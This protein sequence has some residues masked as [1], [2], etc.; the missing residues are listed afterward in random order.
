[1]CDLEISRIGSPY[2]HDISNLKVEANSGKKQ[3]IKFFEITLE[4]REQF[5]DTVRGKQ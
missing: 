2:I 4:T 5:D 1:V 3:R